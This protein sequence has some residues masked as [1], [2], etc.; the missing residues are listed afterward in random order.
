MMEEA[1]RRKLEA[2]YR[3]ELKWIRRGAAARTTKQRF[4]VERFDDIK[5]SLKPQEETRRVEITTGSTRL[6]KK[7]IEIDGISK[8]FG[9]HTLIKDF[10]YMLMRDDRIGVLGENGCG[11]S[12]L[13]KMIAGEEAPD[14]GTVTRAT[15][16][17]RC[18]SIRRTSA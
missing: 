6:G 14:S 17:R 5:D 12:T 16:N 3:S 8:G 7:L 2:L 11:K 10:S 18:P 1:S 4:R 13:L 15:L 9:G